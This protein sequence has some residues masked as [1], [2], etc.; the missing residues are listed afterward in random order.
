MRIREA[1]LSDVRAIAK[2][3]VDTWRSAYQGLIPDVI[4]DKMSYDNREELL[5][6]FLEANEKKIFTYVAE[7]VYGMIIGYVMGGPKRFNN[8]SYDGEIY[9]IYIFDKYQRKGI[10]RLLIREVAKTV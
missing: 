1:V 5:K 7:D 10:G 4:L 2:V 8:I 6:Q 3:N 9:A